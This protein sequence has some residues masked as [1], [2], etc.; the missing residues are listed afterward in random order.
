M[1]R[2]VDSIS[3]MEGSEISYSD[4][5]GSYDTLDELLTRFT[6]EFRPDYVFKLRNRCVLLGQGVTIT[7]RL[8]F[9]A[10]PA[11]DSHQNASCPGLFVGWD[12]L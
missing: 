6:L 8:F 9:P 3:D 4:S 12:P 1:S 5:R 11:F 2:P 7:C 10:L